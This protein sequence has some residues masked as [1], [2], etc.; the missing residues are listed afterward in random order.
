ME[1]IPLC[2]SRSPGAST[3]AA[4]VLFVGALSLGVWVAL[5]F[6]LHYYDA[7]RSGEPVAAGRIYVR[8]FVHEW[9]SEL[10][11]AL[12]YP[13]GVF[14]PAGAQRFDPDG[15]PP[16]VFVPGYGRNRGIFFVL[17]WRLRRYGYR[18]LYPL[19]IGATTTSII[20]LGDRLTT[21]I[22]AIS[23]LTGG[24]KVVAVCHSMGGLVLRSSLKR[25]PETS[26]A[27]MITLGTPHNGTRLAHLGVGESC[28]QMRPGSAFLAELKPGPAVPCVCLYSRL[29][30]TVIPAISAALGDKVIAFEDLGHGTLLYAV[31]V[32]DMVLHELGQ[33][34]LS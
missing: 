15:G 18:N 25:R 34:N 20:D 24:Q 4:L 27:K 7:V 10:A 8:A 13:L 26:V 12:S 14:W 19:S 29:D 16:V 1:P 6:V 5:G 11:E 3:F 28:R 2:V 32:F 17:Y 9:I 33:G 22:E 23:L 21:Q 31:E 30:N